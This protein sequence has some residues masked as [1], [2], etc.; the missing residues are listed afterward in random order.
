MAALRAATDP[1]SL[2]QMPAPPAVEPHAADSVSVVAILTSNDAVRAQELR[3]MR[4]RRRAENSFSKQIVLSSTIL[5][6]GAFGVVYLGVH[7][8]TGAFVAVKKLTLKPVG[9]NADGKEIRDQLDDLVAE[10]RLMKALDHTNIVKYLHADHNDSDLSIYMEFMSGGSLASMLKKF[11]VLTEPL[12]RTFMIQA[13]RGVA[14]LHQRNVV[15]RD[16]KADNI[17]IGAD[18]SAKLSDFGTSRELSD[19]TNLLTVTGT[20]WFMAPEV[21]KGTGHGSAADIWSVGCTIIQLIRGS[22]PFADFPNPITAMYHVAL[23]PQKVLEYIPDSCSPNLRHLL[24][25]CLQEQP[26]MRPSALQI[27]DHPFFSALVDDCPSSP[28]SSRS[29]SLP[30]AAVLQTLEV[31]T[32]SNGLFDVAPLKPRHPSRPTTPNS[33]RVSRLRDE[34]QNQ[35]PS[36]T[37]ASR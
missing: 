32:E 6:S 33:S 1:H 20:P 25:W 9:K 27:L 17:L 11:D 18:G 10:I 26:A 2:L 5:G 24:E 28:G 30:S 29:S 3:D 4:K 21:V 37:L 8:L 15:H 34:T 36:S 19:S 35:Q 13:M 7:Q 16:I 31:R 23:H 22:A 12:V 14:Y